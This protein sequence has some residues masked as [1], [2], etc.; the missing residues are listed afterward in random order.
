MANSRLKYKVQAPVSEARSVTKRG[1]DCRP[2]R[3]EFD[4]VP[5]R[6][7]IMGCAFAQWSPPPLR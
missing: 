1:A 2:F 4:D 5:S 7:W 6:K 3:H